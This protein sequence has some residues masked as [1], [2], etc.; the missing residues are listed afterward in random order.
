MDAQLHVHT[1][2]VEEVASEHNTIH[3]RVH[4]VQ[5]AGRDVHRL[6]RPHLQLHCVALGIQPHILQLTDTLGV[7]LSLVS[8]RRLLEVVEKLL[9][10]LDILRSRRAIRAVRVKPADEVAVVQ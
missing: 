2:E 4:R 5:P 6:T 1:G 3:R 9:I 7:P 8:L 10:I